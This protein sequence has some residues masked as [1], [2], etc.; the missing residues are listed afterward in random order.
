[1]V[2]LKIL[3]EEI[4]EIIENISLETAFTTIADYCFENMID[5][6]KVSDMTNIG[7]TLVLYGDDVTFEI[8]DY[9]EVETEIGK[10]ETEKG[11]KKPIM[12]QT[13]EDFENILN[14]GEE[15]KTI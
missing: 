5:E 12:I 8:E 11:P 1:M 2:T 4:E 10:I 6:P 9:Y 15:E 13:K 14:Y 7:N 3:D